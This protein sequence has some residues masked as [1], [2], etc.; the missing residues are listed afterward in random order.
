MGEKFLGWY[1]DA[2]CTTNK[3]TKAP[4]GN[5]TLYAKYPT[6]ILDKFYAINAY[7]D[8]NQKVANAVGV[9]QN[10]TIIVTSN[11]NG[12]FKVPAYDATVTDGYIFNTNT[13]YLVNIYYNSIAIVGEAESA[14]VQFI[15]GD[16]SITMPTTH[17]R[18]CP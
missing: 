15:R 17:P 9:Q 1:T 5:V 3:V 13:K 10:G 4:A 8:G 6:V 2:T 18:P 16:F 12:A 14:S 7:T 11:S